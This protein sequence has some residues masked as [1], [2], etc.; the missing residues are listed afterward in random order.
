MEKIK[1]SFSLEGAD[2]VQPSTSASTFF[3]IFKKCSSVFQ[4][5]IKF[6]P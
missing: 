2:L 1:K 3:E 5:I 6:I 4:K